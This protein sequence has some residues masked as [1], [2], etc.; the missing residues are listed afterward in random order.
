ME[1]VLEAN[2]LPGRRDTT[3]AGGE[4]EL[5][6]TRKRGRNQRLFRHVNK[7]IQEAHQAFQL[8]P[9]E[10]I[11]FVCE[12]ADRSCN[13]QVKVGIVDYKRIPRTGGFFVLKPG[14]EQGR[15]AHRR[16]DRRY[17]VSRT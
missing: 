4:C 3:F 15:A 5:M 16:A 12:C 14:H 8:S 1:A 2:G 6:P 7:R 10:Q 17:V 9:R 11:A 13:E